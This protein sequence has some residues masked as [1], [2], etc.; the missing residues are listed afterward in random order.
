MKLSELKRLSGISRQIEADHDGESHDAMKAAM[1][2]ITG[3][4]VE[5]SVSG[6]SG[7][8]K[9]MYHISDDLYVTFNDKS[10]LGDIYYRGK[11]IDSFRGIGTPDMEKLVKKYMKKYGVEPNEME[12]ISKLAGINKDVEVDENL[13]TI[14]GDEGK[15]GSMPGDPHWFDTWKKHIDLFPRDTNASDATKEIDDE[16][17]QKEKDREKEIEQAAKKREQEVEKQEQEKEEKRKE[18]EEEQEAKRK[19]EEEAA[20]K[21]KEEE[22]AR[23]EE[24][25]EDLESDDE[26]I[27]EED[28]LNYFGEK[29]NDAERTNR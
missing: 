16:E 12:D 29:F 8:Q 3:N 11:N 10:N 17:E 28:L 5:T 24:V 18:E 20:R 15:D 4:D 9:K 21:E 7:F 2:K 27:D 25:G 19:E 6:A 26:A 23:D 13:S 14:G 22:E 1:D